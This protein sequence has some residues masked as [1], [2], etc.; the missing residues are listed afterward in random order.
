M[1][2]LIVDDHPLVLQSVDFVLQSSG[3]QT[4]LA[5]DFL[6]AKIAL[7]DKF[8]CLLLD[9][10]LADKSGLDLLSLPNI[11]LPENIVIFSGMSDP[12]DIIFALEIS[13]ALAFISKQIDLTDL[14]KAIAQLQ[15]LDHQKIWV[16][17]S[18]QQEFVLALEGFKQYE[19]LTPKERQVF[20]LLRQ[21]LLDKQIA[22]E[23]E[24]SIHTIRVQIRSIKRKRKTIRRSV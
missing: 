24:R 3:Y 11:Y 1:R 17:E 2:I 8:D 16:W 12:E 9:Y 6:S 7:Q 18:A 19:I 4:V 10:N 20:M 21:G 23:L 15:T 22:D 14:Q 13:P 5:K